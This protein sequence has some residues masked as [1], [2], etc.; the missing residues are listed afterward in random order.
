MLNLITL[1]DIRTALSAIL[2]G[3][4]EEET[5]A[6]K[7]GFREATAD[8]Q[9]A[10]LQELKPRLDKPVLGAFVLLYRVSQ[11]LVEA[12][13]EEHY[14]LR[15]QL[16][17]TAPGKWHKD[18]PPKDPF[19]AM[20]P[21]RI[22]SWV[23]DFLA[24]GAIANKVSHAVASDER[25]LCC[26]IKDYFG[27]GGY[28]DLN[29][30]RAIDSTDPTMQLFLQMV[31]R[32]LSTLRPEWFDDHGE[33]L[34]SDQLGPDVSQLSL[35]E[36]DEAQ[37][38]RMAEIRA[39]ERRAAREKKKKQEA[40]K[41][42]STIK[43]IAE[44]L[45]SIAAFQEILQNIEGLTAPEACVS[46]FDRL[47]DLYR[48]GSLLTTDLRNQAASW[49]DV[50]TAIM[51][52]LGEPGEDEE[53]VAYYTKEMDSLILQGFL[54]AIQSIRPEWFSPLATG[55]LTF[56]RGIPR[57]EEPKVNVRGRKAVRAH[58]EAD[59]EKYGSGLVFP[60]LREFLGGLALEVE[61]DPAPSA[62]PSQAPEDTEE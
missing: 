52:F 10:L 49:P 18:F 8:E 45:P 1:T 17:G 12:D 61:G 30:S 14:A 43:V 56:R 39:E 59:I 23:D 40:K 24:A 26:T 13:S 25:G 55:G 28:E 38:A 27:V 35:F 3:E 32:S 57:P 11:G 48:Q 41:R 46:E 60:I 51:G 6:A 33:L 5:T 42:Q 16:V 9:L 50:S 54:A 7:A 37:K 47:K 21:N 53:Q 36:L 29:D 4:T 19:Q 31:L 44:S 58:L 22:P 2:T 20:D 34:A 62:S 15:K